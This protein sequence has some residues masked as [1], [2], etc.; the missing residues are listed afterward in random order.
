VGQYRAGRYP[1]AID[2]VVPIG[3]DGAAVKGA[4]RP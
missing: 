2:A 4:W 1:G 3:R